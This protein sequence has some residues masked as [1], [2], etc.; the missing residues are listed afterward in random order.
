[1]SEPTSSHPL[2]V[3]P[4]CNVLIH[5]KALHSLPWEEWGQDA[6]EIL[7][8]GPVLGELDTVKNRPGR[9]GRLARDV[10]AEI[11]KLLAKPGHEDVLR[12]VNPRV[13]RRLWLGQ[14]EGR[15][16]L[17]E[18]IE[19]AHGDQAIINRALWWLDSGRDVVFLTDDTLAAA[20]AQEFGL[21]YR[22]LPP[23]WLRPA[24]TDE[25]QK[26]TARLKAEIA[27]LQASEPQLDCWF[28]DAAGQR[29]KRLDATLKH[30][31]ALAPELV[32]ALV[33]R[34]GQANPMV[35]LKPPAAATT[36]TPRTGPVDIATI[37]REF[38][39]HLS[40]IM[41]RA[42]AK[43]EED[44][45]AWLERV[46]GQLRELHIAW[47]RRREWP[48]AAFI[49]V[50]TGNRPGSKALVE[51]V[52]GGNFTI[53]RPR[54]WTGEAKKIDDQ[55]R[56]CELSIA[57]PPAPP[58]PQL[59]AANLLGLSDSALFGRVPPRFADPLGT[60]SRTRDADAFYWRTGREDPTDRMELE[61][62]NWRH[63]REPEDFPFQIGGSDSQSLEGV[64]TGTLSA[65]NLTASVQAR[66]PVRI[67]FT[68]QPLEPIAEQ[69][70]T[71][72]ERVSPRWRQ[73]QKIVEPRD[74]DR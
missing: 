34:V 47:R 73:A 46:R 59:A 63:Q 40:P 15:E 68:D 33:V 27:R 42:I 35:R 4:D 60:L 49:G 8:V 32:E 5:G 10:N 44:Y 54:K 17:R 41:A 43:Y 74:A 52:V 16:P 6:I 69:M 20:S 1:M 61:C 56:L 24:E 55:K 37:G 2:I 7:I 26:E 39:R 11:R 70:V 53:Q 28:E 30:H 48:T 23:A 51:M 19:I 25:A 22:L 21:P 71:E 31:A 50:N 58:K 67:A 38:E 13:T 18:G 14:K 29:I 36:P 57:M 66:L 45:A 72:F 62:E 12:V 9:P 64:V 65:A 3:V